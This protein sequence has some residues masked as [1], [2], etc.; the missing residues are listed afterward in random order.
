MRALSGMAT[1]FTLT[2]SISRERRTVLA[3]EMGPLGRIGVDPDTL[4]A[5]MVPLFEPIFHSASPGR[6]TLLQ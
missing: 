2:E 5:V 4:L 6:A 1:L 3:I